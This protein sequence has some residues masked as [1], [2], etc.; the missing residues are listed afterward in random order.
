MEDY[1]PL[2]PGPAAERV[3]WEA[4]SGWLDS[5]EF[6]WLATTRPSGRP[7]SVPIGGVWLGS[8]LYF[9]MAPETVTAR[10][11]ARNPAVAVNLGDPAQVVILEGTAGTLR[12]EEVPDAVL[13]L[14]GGKYGDPAHRPDPA[15]PGI[16]WYAVSPSKILAWVFPDMRGTAQR[17]RF[18]PG[19]PR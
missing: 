2:E 1:G 10:N 9:N 16:D 3:S 4:V 12:P 13:D 15:T 18:S 6:F 11:L 17:W 19:A 5:A 14:Y 8:R 7:H